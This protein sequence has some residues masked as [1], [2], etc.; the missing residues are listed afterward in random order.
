PVRLE[1][2]KDQSDTVHPKRRQIVEF[3]ADIDGEIWIVTV[4]EHHNAGLEVSCPLPW[5]EDLDERRRS[6]RSAL[7]EPSGMRRDFDR[8]RGRRKCRPEEPVGRGAGKSDGENED[9]HP[10]ESSP[11]HLL[12]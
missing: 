1:D 7:T 5:A 9:G 2:R 6:W 8:R 12:P 3:A 10:R 11:H 4:N